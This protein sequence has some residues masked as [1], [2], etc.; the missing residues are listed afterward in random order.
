MW[1][2]RLNDGKHD[3]AKAFGTAIARQ[4][5]IDTALELRKTIKNE[6]KKNEKKAQK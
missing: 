1:K 3:V 6:M 2:C 4:A 5:A